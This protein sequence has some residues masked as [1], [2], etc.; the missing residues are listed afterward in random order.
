MARIGYQ[1]KPGMH[2]EDAPEHARR[3]LLEILYS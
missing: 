2:P 3:D 1:S